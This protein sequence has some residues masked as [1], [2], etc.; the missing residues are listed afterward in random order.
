MTELDLHLEQEAPE[1]EVLPDAHAP[2]STLA[3]ASCI[4]SASCP[5]MTYGTASTVSSGG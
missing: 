5:V 3:S 4:G 2:G 1:L